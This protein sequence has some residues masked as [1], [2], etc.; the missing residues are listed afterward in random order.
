LK[1]LADPDLDIRIITVDANTKISLA[2]QKDPAQY[3]KE[4]Q[5]FQDKMKQSSTQNRSFSTANSF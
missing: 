2:V 5:D 4:L 1:P 3:Q